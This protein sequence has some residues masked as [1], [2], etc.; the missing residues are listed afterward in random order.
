MSNGTFPLCVDLDGTL[1]RTDLL[2]ESLV[3]LLKR[4]PAYVFLLF[5][6]LLRGKSHLKEQVSQRVTIDVGLLP[7]NDRLL[8]YLRA[9]R[10][11]G[12][13]LYLYTAAND[14]FATQIAAHFGFFSGVMASDA[15]LNLRGN[16]K[17]D[18]L[19]SRF[20]DHGFD[21]CGNDRSDLPVWQHAHA[22]IVVGN[23]RIAAAARRVNQE[24]VLFSEARPPVGVVLKAM[25]VYQWCKNILVFVPLLAAHQFSDRQAI[26]SALIAFVAFGL[27]ASSVYLINDMLDLDADRR[28]VRKRARPFASGLLPIWFGVALTFALIAL[29]AVLATLL[30]AHFGLVLCGYFGLTLA[31]SFAL[32]RF[33]LIDVFSL[34]ALYTARIVAGAAAGGIPLSYWLILFSGLIFLSLAMLKRYAELTQSSKEGTPAAAGRGYLTQ[35]LA[36]LRT[37]GCASG[38]TAVLVLALYMRSAEVSVMYRHQAGLWVLFW[39]TLFWISHMW[40]IAFRGQM[41]DDPILFAVKNKLSLGVIAACVASVVLAS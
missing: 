39:L 38:Y 20:G 13:A 16:H 17:A 12:R 34:A 3:V 2:A 24:I 32:K 15:A 35:D 30:P 31:Y 11:R 7:Y 26:V 33:M 19:V 37:F 25:R 27:C 41:D 28:H 22:A 5:V 29:T 10:R 9:E 8:H 36:I 14:K 18:A 40:M 21:Y 1:T 6:W 23:R 4:N